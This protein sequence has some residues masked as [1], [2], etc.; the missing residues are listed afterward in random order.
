MWSTCH[1]LSLLSGSQGEPQV[2]DPFL[3]PL[4]LV[5]IQMPEMAVGI[6]WKM[7]SNTAYLVLYNLIITDLYT[8]QEHIWGNLG[9]KKYTSKGEKMVSFPWAGFHNNLHV[10]GK[11]T[12]LCVWRTNSLMTYCP[13]MSDKVSSQ[14]SIRSVRHN[15]VSGYVQIPTAH[16]CRC[17]ADGSACLKSS[18]SITDQVKW[19]TKIT[20][21]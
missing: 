20:L 18:R 4:D 17:Y 2:P 19:L 3:G 5:L 11:T 14:Y 13:F 8:L 15:Q 10:K 21:Q 16:W 6:I 1:I 9:W 12:W 7:N